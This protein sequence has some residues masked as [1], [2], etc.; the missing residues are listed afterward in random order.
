MSA[1][2]DHEVYLRAAL[3]AAADSLEPN[4]DGLERIRTRLQRARPAPI[5]LALVVWTEVFRRA[6]AWLQDLVY[7][8]AA[9]FTVAWERF[10]PQPAP[11]RHRSRAQGW[12]RPL[13]AMG[14]VMFIVAGG[15]YVAIDG[16][17]A[18]FPS[19]ANSQPGG[20]T[21][22]NG[23]SGTPASGASRAKGSPS[24]PGSG[25]H[26]PAAPCTTAQPN[27]SASATASPSDTQA[28]SP[29]PTPSDSNS[30]GTPSPSPSPTDTSSAGTGAGGTSPTV[31]AGQST[32][33]A[34]GSTSAGT[35]VS[36]PQPSPCSSGSRS[37]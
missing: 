27:P 1:H 37:R 9:A 12:L 28:T 24:A 34:A 20:G 16:S 17:T 22:A 4:A 19:S 18:I 36:Q 21:G 30:T 29:S 11:G 10:G 14:V 5:A 31:P 35:T 3:H 26:S 2:S 6:P 23:H 32:T 8:T 7:R 15:V 25:S 13:A 33:Q